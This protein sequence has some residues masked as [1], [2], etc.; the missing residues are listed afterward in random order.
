MVYC[1][2][3]DNNI[4]TKLVG[5]IKI[6]KMKHRLTIDFR[7]SASAKDTDFQ[8]RTAVGRQKKRTISIAIFFITLLHIVAIKVVYRPKIVFEKALLISFL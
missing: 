8:K 6:K 2:V 5:E 1:R 3:V 4:T 7:N